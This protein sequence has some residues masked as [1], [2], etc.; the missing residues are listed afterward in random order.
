MNVCT[1]SG[2]LTRDAETRYTGSGTA[3]TNFCIA[4]D[5][6]FGEHKRTDFINCV[7]WKREGLVQ[8]LTKGKAVMVSGEYQ[9]RKWQDKD[10]NN[11]ETVEIVIRDV[12]FQQGERSQQGQQQ[13]PQQRRNEFPSDV[14]G[15]DDV[16]FS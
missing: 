6:G 14:G 16:P 13:A 15:M 7:L 4:V 10:G 1:F 9:A 11:R 8:H 3:V 2:R 5:T 12:D